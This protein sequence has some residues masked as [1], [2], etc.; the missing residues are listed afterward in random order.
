MDQ[1][2]HCQQQVLQYIV[3]YYDFY[4]VLKLTKML[5]TK[6]SSNKNVESDPLFVACHGVVPCPL[7]V[8]LD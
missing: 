2:C 1:T 5:K 8:G 3:Q 6:R 4:Y 7:G